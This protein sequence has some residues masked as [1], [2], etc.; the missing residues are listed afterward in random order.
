[1][2]LD[3]PRFKLRK[4]FSFFSLLLTGVDEMMLLQVG[5][6]RETLGANV[7]LERPLAGMSPQMYLE[8]RQL[9]ERLATHVA[10]VMHLAVLLLQRVRQRP[11]TPRPLRVRA[12]RAALRAA[13]VVRGQGAR[14]RV[15]VEGGRGV[16]VDGEA[17]VV[18]QVEVVRA[19]YQRLV[20][21]YLHRGR[22]RQLMTA[23]RGL[24]PPPVRPL[25]NH[26]PARGRR[27]GGAVD[28]QRGHVVVQRAVL[29]VNTV[30]V[31][32]GRLYG[33][34]GGYALIAVG[35]RVGV[36]G[37]RVYL[38]SSRA[39]VEDGG[40]GRARAPGGIRRRA[41]GLSLG[42]ATLVGRGRRVKVARGREYRGGG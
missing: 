25:V 40:R 39:R 17:R 42:R 4:T 18:A 1:M 14:G 8:I 5:Q 37:A 36:D 19:S 10:L 3:H 16:G 22:G 9:A 2:Y 38:A 13:V 23:R 33:G 6:L 35:R 27:I 15:S 21:V 26:V 12:E 11:V 30:G 34:D 41:L 32:G 24:Q 28:G 7:T 29:M 20:P 31:G